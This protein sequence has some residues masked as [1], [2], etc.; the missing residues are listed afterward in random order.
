MERPADRPNKARRNEAATS[1]REAGWGFSLDR[2]LILFLDLDGPSA[3]RFH[4]FHPEG[5]SVEL[6]GVVCSAAPLALAVV[7]SNDRAERSAR[8]RS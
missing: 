3:D 1:K 8:K 2:R 6:A 4:A 5:A 7:R